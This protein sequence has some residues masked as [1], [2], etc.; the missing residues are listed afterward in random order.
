[1]LPFLEVVR[2]RK[3][4]ASPQA[5][6][7]IAAAHPLARALIARLG[8]RTDL[9]VLDFAAGSGR[10]TRALRAAGLR[11]ASVADSIAES[12]TPLAGLTGRFA[13]ALSTHGLLHGTPPIVSN[14]VGAI[15]QRLAPGGLL[16]ATFASSRDA[17][18]GKGE[19]IDAWTY[20]PI[21]GDERGVAHAYFDRA[22]LLGL[23]E[24]HFTIESLDERSVDDIV[25]A[26]AHRASPLRGAMHW[27]AI[28]SAASVAS[29]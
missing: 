12:A 28:A 3:P 13:A 27:F 7:T 15:A 25:G 21:D 24:P 17:R 20:A 18:F 23:L 5:P 6:D 2:V 19:R 26:W 8:S 1:V 29:R 9:M 22:G 16:Y 10:N 11:V 14:N 4:P